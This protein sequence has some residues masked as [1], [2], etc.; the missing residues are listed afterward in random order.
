MPRFLLLGVA[1]ALIGCAAVEPAEGD[2]I[3][4]EKLPRVVYTTDPF[5]IGER[6]SFGH[7]QSEW[8]D[9]N[10]GR[11]RVVAIELIAS[12]GVELV[13]VGA[14]D[15]SRVDVGVGLVPGWPPAEPT[16]DTV[17]DE[18][19]QRDWPDPSVFVLG[20]EVQATRAGFRGI[21]TRWID[22][23]GAQRT[24]VQDVAA[25]TCSDPSCPAIGESKE[26]LLCEL[27]LWREAGACP[28]PDAVASKASDVRQP[29]AR[30]WAVWRSAPA[31]AG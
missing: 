21:R 23:S 30:A 27:G 25:V 10:Q 3:P 15:G 29:G 7:Y 12:S 4:L 16:L 11:I 8:G 9:A 1:I 28:S 24:S 20:I 14:F 19:Y 26:Q 5:V 6:Y 13:G 31:P 22:E 17:G 2:G 18:T